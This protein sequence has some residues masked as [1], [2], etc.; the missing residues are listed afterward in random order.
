MSKMSGRSR[1]KEGSLGRGYMDGIVKYLIKRNIC[2][3]PELLSHKAHVITATI[4]TSMPPC[5]NSIEINRPCVKVPGPLGEIYMGNVH[6]KDTSYR[7][8]II[9]R[10]C[11]LQV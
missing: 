10:T 4:L 11:S 1:E 9:S 8:L 5:C 2:S 3:I 6:T 7:T